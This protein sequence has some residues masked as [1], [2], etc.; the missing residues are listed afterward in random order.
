MSTRAAREQGARQGSGRTRTI[1]S[2]TAVALVAGGLTYAAVRSEGETVHRS[3]LDDGGVW[4]T[5]AQ[6]ARFGRVN[7]AIKQL[8][9]GVAADVAEEDR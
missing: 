1:A 3:D 9:A 2:A 5:S 7:Q 6:Q 8:D 4:V